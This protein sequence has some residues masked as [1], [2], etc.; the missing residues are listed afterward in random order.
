MHLFKG[1]ERLGKKIGSH[2][3]ESELILTS[4][5]VLGITPNRKG[6]IQHDK[7][8]ISK[9]FH[10]AKARPNLIPYKYIY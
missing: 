6:C 10:K 3:Q 7:T 4:R 8:P 9:S 1:E 2:K 5:Q